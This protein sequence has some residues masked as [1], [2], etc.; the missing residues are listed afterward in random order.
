MKRVNVDHYIDAI[1]YTQ[2]RVLEI[3]EEERIVGL[4][5][6][7]VLWR[8]ARALASGR[9]SK[10]IKF[11]TNENVG[12]GKLELAENEMHATAF[13]ITLGHELL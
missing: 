3:A 8:R 1:R 6:R 4:A 7:A 9:D 10:K 13:W 11:F 5:A 2:V 12:A